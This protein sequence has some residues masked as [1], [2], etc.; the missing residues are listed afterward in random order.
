MN[1]ECDKIKGLIA[2]SVTGILSPDQAR[3]LDEHLSGCSD[4]R[5][6][7]DALKHEDMLLTQLV[8]GL[9]ADMRNRQQRL[10]ETLDRCQSEQRETITKWRI[11]MKSRITK[12]AAAAAIIIAVLIG[13]HQFASPI[14]GTS[15]VWA[16][17]ACKMETID[18][19]TCRKREREM[20]S[21]IQDGFKFV[22]E[23]E[24]MYWCSVEYGTKSEHYSNGELTS[25]SYRLCKT[26]EIVA[27][28]PPAKMYNRLRLSNEAL[29]EEMEMTPREIVRRFLSSDYK[30]LGPDFIDGKRVEG[31]EVKDQNI[32]K[33]SGREPEM[34]DFVA[35]LWVDVKIQLP[36]Q[37]KVEYSLAGADGS[38]RNIMVT[39]HF[40]WN[41]ELTASDFEPNIPTGYV[42]G[43]DQ[44]GTTTQQ[45]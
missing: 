29:L 44:F 6:Y 9:D 8:A 14:G 17:V 12:L 13:I 36:V 5:N 19:F 11:I 30:P 38:V 4:C 23:K 41:V 43:T 20:S 28:F 33:Y 7:A 40:Q 2:D 21:P 15:V 45:K 32:L 24:S 42:P 22:K 16:D 18:S 10:L 39:D 25:R 26:K 3:Q 35:R 37:L 31:V 34:Q 1:R 27:I